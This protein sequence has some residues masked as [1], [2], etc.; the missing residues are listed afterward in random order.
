MPDE[1]RAKVLD[2]PALLLR[3]FDLARGR[4]LTIVPPLLEDIH[5]HVEIVSVGGLSNAGGESHVPVHLGGARHGQDVGSHASR[6][7]AGKVGARLAHGAR[8]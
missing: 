3:L 8:I 1:Q 2:N 7:C 4:T 6:P 5:R